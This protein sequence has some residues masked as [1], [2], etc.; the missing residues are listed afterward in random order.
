VFKL[1]NLQWDGGSSKVL[2]KTPISL[3]YVGTEFHVKIMMDSF[4]NLVF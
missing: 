1:C 2:W 4:R 3:R